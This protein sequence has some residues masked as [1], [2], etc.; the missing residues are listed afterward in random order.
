M[1]PPRRGLGCSA[2]RR[3]QVTPGAAARSTPAAAASAGGGA[4]SSNGAAPGRGGERAPAGRLAL[5]TAWYGGVTVLGL[6]SGLLMSIVLAR[7]LGP[8]AMGDFSY[9]IWAQRLLQSAATLGLG[10]ATVRYTAD[11]LGRGEPARAAGYLAVFL[12]WQFLATTVVVIAV[13]P[14]ILALAPHAMRWAFVAAILTLFPLTLEGIY[15][16]AT[17]GAQRYDLTARVST[18]KMTLILAVTVGVLL[19]G[20]GVAAV[21]AAE[22]LAILGSCLLQR[23]QARSLYPAPAFAP[24]VRWSEVRSYLLPLSAVV[25][26][27]ILVWDR[28]E[29]FFL[30]LWTTSQEIAF[31]SLGY[32]LA[33]RIMVLPGIVVGPLLPAFAALDGR[34]EHAEFRRVYRT[35]VRWAA[36]AGAAIAAVGAALA[37]ALIVLLYGE[38]YR[39]AAWVFRALVL[40]SAMGAVRDVAWTALQAAGDRRAILHASI[41]S[42]IVDLG[43]AIGLIPWLGTVGA[44]IAASAAQIT[45]S[46]WAFVAIHRM[47]G[48]VLPG[49]DLAGIVGGAVI[50]FAVA[51]AVGSERHALPVIAG[52]GAAGLAVFV[53][54]STALGIIRH[55]E[56]RTVARWARA[57]WPRVP[58][59]PSA[60]PRGQ[61]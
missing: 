13:T 56:W 30:R 1:A 46:L 45:I 52:A 60:A 11:A 18:V 39:P 42:V 51:H 28:T 41:V 14:A 2:S 16:R 35:A 6:G 59:R 54:A 4:P 32:G 44:V 38:A 26:L 48:A 21:L 33:A 20:G 22:G 15:M 50:A 8:T 23:R 25:L 5:N 47:K 19:L 57:A 29:V 27:E 37:P 36:L 58:R 40:V 12:R 17:Y 10:V 24:G 34:G 9:I 49:R 3:A 61:T 55:D 43:L 7:G 31:Y 53:A